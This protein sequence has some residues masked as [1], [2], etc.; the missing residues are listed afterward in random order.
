MEIL[1]RGRKKLFGERITLPLADDMLQA[2]DASLGK[3]EPR[4][5]FVREAIQRELSRR[6]EAQARYYVRATLSEVINGKVFFTT[7]LR[8]RDVV[9]FEASEYRN[10]A[11]EALDAI[12]DQ[13]AEFAVDVVVIVGTM[14]HAIN[15]RGTDDNAP[16]EA[17]RTYI[18]GEGGYE[19]LNEFSVN[20]ESF[21]SAVA[22]MDLAKRMR[23]TKTSNDT[24]KTPN[25]KTRAA[26]EEARAIRAAKSANRHE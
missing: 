25:E 2:V 10:T 9:V 21:A 17:G 13:G 11:S 6:A 20:S 3:G 18:R 24:S 1:A 22:A 7:Q 5:A 16:Y 4:L 23:T 8:S 15:P 14:P 26:I 12:L 19:P